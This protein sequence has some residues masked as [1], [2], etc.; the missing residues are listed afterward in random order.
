MWLAFRA[1]ATKGIGF[2]TTVQ[3]QNFMCNAKVF[4]E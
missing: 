4:Q 1:A 3:T 2:E